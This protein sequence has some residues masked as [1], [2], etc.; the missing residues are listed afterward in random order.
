MK[1]FLVQKLKG[2]DQERLYAYLAER[3]LPFGLKYTRTT[4]CDWGYYD[5][6]KEKTKK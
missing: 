5:L 2:Y 4:V 3:Y 1:K 6:N